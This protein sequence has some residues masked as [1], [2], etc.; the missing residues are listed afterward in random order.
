MIKPGNFITVTLSGK[1]FYVKVTE[2]LDSE[3]EVIY[4]GMTLRIPKP[5]ETSG[6]WIPL[7]ELHVTP[8][9]TSVHVDTRDFRCLLKTGEKPLNTLETQIRSGDLKEWLFFFRD[10]CGGPGVWREVMTKD[11]IWSFKYLRFR[12][13]P[14]D[15]FGVYDRHGNP[16]DLGELTKENLKISALL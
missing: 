15:G 4:E 7:E 6:E 11:G 3:I 12:R 13:G 8:E 1:Q 5:E 10:I 16:V 9:V 14:G 2:V